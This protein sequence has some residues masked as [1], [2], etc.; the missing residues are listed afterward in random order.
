L[1]QQIADVCPMHR[2]LKNMSSEEVALKINHYTSK[3][4]LMERNSDKCSEVDSEEMLEANEM[5]DN[6]MLCRNT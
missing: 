2:D 4:T 5:G 3:M 6:D 1:Y